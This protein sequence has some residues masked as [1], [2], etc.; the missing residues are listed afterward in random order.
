MHPI[1]TGL[2]AL[3]THNIDFP[4]RGYFKDLKVYQWA[5][6][7]ATINTQ[8]VKQLSTLPVLSNNPLLRGCCRSKNSRSQLQ[9]GQ[10]TGDNITQTKTPWLPYISRFINWR[11]K[12]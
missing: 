8:K 5:F 11:T 2:D 1:L 9:P 4:K 3:C 7:A 10:Y 12:K 6:G